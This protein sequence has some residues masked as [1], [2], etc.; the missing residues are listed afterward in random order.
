MSTADP[1]D[2]EWILA[3]CDTWAII[4]L[5]DNPARPAHGVARFLQR[6]GKR[7]V[8]VH[9]KAETVWGKPGY[10]SLADIPF[11]VDCVDVF[12]RSEDAGAFA[13]EAITIGAKAVWFQ[14]LVVDDAAGQRAVDAGLRFVQ[15]R[16][17]AIEWP[18]FGPA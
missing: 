6:H 4:G 17:P 1:G 10:R 16:C 11:Q 7:V 3:N 15:D 9:P 8:P 2:I 18:K 13:D 12:R 14:L 5:A